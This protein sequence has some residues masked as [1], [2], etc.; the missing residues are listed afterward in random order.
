MVV[1][2]LHRHKENKMMSSGSGKV[3]LTPGLGQRLGANVSFKE[4]NILGFAGH[5]AELCQSMSHENYMQRWSHQY[6]D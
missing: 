3:S 6:P 5:T 2:Y 4:S 1:T